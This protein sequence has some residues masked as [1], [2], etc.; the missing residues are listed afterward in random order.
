MVAAGPGQTG[1]K[2]SLDQEQH[3]RPDSKA[4]QS[5]ETIRPHFV[6]TALIANA[7]TRKTDL[8][9]AVYE[10]LMPDA[11]DAAMLYKKQLT[12]RSFDLQAGELADV[13]QPAQAIADDCFIVDSVT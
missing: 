10:V 2:E 12:H 11:E 4:R 5:L 13:S 8:D 7:W 9:L 6:S 3:E 1:R